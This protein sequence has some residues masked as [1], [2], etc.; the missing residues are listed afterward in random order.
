VKASFV[1]VNYNR[2]EEL[3]ITLT[4]T[5]E[6]INTIALNF[7]I[8]VVDNASTDGSLQAVETT[9]PDVVLIQ[10][11]TNTG[12]PAWNLGFEKARG[13][14][15]IILDDDSHIES[16][17]EEAIRFLDE[18]DNVGILAL[19]VT[20]GLYQTNEWVDLSEQAGFIGCGAIFRKT[21][22]DKI[23]GYANWI[24]LYTNEY[25]LGI[26]AL[27]A[28]YKI[29]YYKTCR[30]KHRASKSHRTSKRLIVFSVAHELAIIYKYFPHNRFKYLTR[31]FLN[32]LKR[33]KGDGVRAPLY[34]VQGAIKFLKMR[35][36][37]VYTPVSNEIQ[38]F[39]TS[40]F[41]ST[42]PV[43]YKFQKNIGL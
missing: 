38:T 42:F 1:I 26:R 20:G 3:L 17:L 14:Y 13:D 6:I 29:I 24:F 31:L 8:V 2:K 41:K 15:F 37:L 23:G 12:A 22:Y 16:G 43:F 5:R 33:I 39:F 25:D 32:N 4:K 18:N 30:V 7:E 27:N 40:Q 34:V 21:L 28:G 11:A 36:A 9:F 19:N 10:N 35:K